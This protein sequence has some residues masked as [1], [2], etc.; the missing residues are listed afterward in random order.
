MPITA[1]PPLFLAANERW[2]GY[3]AQRRR[4]LEAAAGI[5]GVLWLAG[6][7]HFAAVAR[8]D[9]PDGPFF[10]QTEVLVGPV[11][12][13]NPAL[14]VVQLTGDER[15]FPFLSGE[16]NFG[17]LTFDAASSPKTITI[18]HVGESGAVFGRYVLEV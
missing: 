11:A 13:L 3:A 8:V 10:A 16:R 9:P 17:R 12:H 7:F 4:V 14:A 1:W 15:Q 6:D 2:Q 18:E 5:P